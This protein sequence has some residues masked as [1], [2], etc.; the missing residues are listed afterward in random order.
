MQAPGR[1]C[2]GVF[3]ASVTTLVLKF[4]D[5]SKTGE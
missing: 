2:M 5:A 1:F 3:V 4:I